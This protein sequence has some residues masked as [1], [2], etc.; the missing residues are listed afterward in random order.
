MSD[1]SP[2]KMM[3]PAEMRD[4]IASRI[5]DFDDAAAAKFRLAAE[6]LLKIATDVLQAP[7][8]ERASLYQ[9]A[10]TAGAGLGL[11]MSRIPERYGPATETYLLGMWKVAGHAELVTRGAVTS[12]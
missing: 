11:D 4:D 9:A 5:A 3:T 2:V 7:L 6:F 1:D 8:A 10:R 12:H